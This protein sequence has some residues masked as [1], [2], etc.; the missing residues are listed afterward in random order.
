MPFIAAD[1]EPF[2]FFTA[3]AIADD[4][5]TII[6]IA[7]FYPPR[8]TCLALP[9]SA[10]KHRCSGWSMPWSNGSPYLVLPLFTWLAP[11]MLRVKLIQGVNW[12][13]IVGVGFL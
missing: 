3:F 2:T 4:L 12:P 9:V 10:L 11:K 5:G 6:V 1:K 8:Y 7:L 13:M